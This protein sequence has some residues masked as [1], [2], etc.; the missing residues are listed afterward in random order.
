VTPR[1]LTELASLTFLAASVGCVVPVGPEW[2]DPQTN[3]P[4]TIDYAIPPIGDVLTLDADGGAPM[5]LEVGLAD[6]NTQDKLYVRW[7]IDYPPYQDGIS[8]LAMPLQL[9]GGNQIKRPP[10]YFAPSCS[11]DAL[12]HDF[13]NHRLLLAV[14]DR[15]FSLPNNFNFSQASP[16]DQVPTGNFLV[17]GSWQF[18]LDCH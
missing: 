13:S 12:S 7:I 2:T 6:Q 16:P 3:V 17:K 5:S 10:I 4:P 18:V 1:R 11:D 9:P 14:S 15:P 8:H